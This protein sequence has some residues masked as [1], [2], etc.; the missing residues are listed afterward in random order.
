MFVP[1]MKDKA[2]KERRDLILMHRLNETE[3]R[4]LQAGAK[5]S[6]M[7]VSAYLRALV[8]RDNEPLQEV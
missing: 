1:D 3:K 6:G 4:M 7:K 8:R 5:K 2:K